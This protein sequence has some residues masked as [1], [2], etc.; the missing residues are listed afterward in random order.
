MIQ[1][2]LK[3][4]FTTQKIGHIKFNKLVT[5]HLAALEA[6]TEK[7]KL[8]SQI[9]QLT[10]LHTPYQQWISVQD[11]NKIDKT[12]DTDALNIVLHDFIE[13]V[14]GDLYR[15]INYHFAKEPS[16]LHE[17]YPNKRIEYH[18]INRGNALVLLQRVVDFC[19][20]Y[21][22]KLDAGRDVQSKKFLDDYDAQQDEQLDSKKTVSH[23]S[24]TGN[25]LRAA[26]AEYMFDVLLTLLSIHKANRYDVLNYYNLSILTSTA[27]KEATTEE[28]GK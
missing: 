22:A 9:S 28:K 6:S 11:K 5:E 25:A 20:K 18:H 10:A 15:D 4:P 7:A 3:N 27:K 14:T 26:I 12:G 17:I 13:F 21:K 2:F 24:S 8:T 19:E 16:V 1:H 23:G